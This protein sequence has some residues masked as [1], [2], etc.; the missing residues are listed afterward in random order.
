[1]GGAHNQKTR[2]PRSHSTLHFVSGEL[3]IAM[4]WKLT[5]PPVR[6]EYDPLM[7]THNQNEIATL[8]SLV[9]DDMEI[10]SAPGEARI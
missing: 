7:G 3:R 8:V 5:A 4:T 9:R 10:D 1:M 2:S 6:L